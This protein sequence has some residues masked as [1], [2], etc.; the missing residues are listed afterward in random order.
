MVLL[1]RH[2][3]GDMHR[4]LHHNHLLNHHWLLNNHHLLMAMH[5]VALLLMNGLGVVN[6]DHMNGLGVMQGRQ[7]LGVVVAMDGGREALQLPTQVSSQGDVICS[8]TGT[9]AAAAAFVQRQARM[10]RLHHV[11]PANTMPGG[12]WQQPH[13]TCYYSVCIKLTAANPV[14]L[15][16]MLD[17]RHRHSM[18]VVAPR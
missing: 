16:P 10:R 4:L 8:T 3:H 1:D 15:G 7:R 5:I 14:C 17:S 2:M 9:A 12:K 11:W 18:S 6:W 13:V